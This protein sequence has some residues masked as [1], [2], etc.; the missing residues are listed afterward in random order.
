MSQR[1]RR[2]FA[3]TEVLVAIVVLTLA[4]TGA[5]GLIVRSV[6][7]LQHASHAERRMVRA[8]EVIT[9]TTLRSRA[10]LEASGGSFQSDELTVQVT[11]LSSDLFQISVLD[12]AGAPLLTTSVY[13]PYAH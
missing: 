5:V 4:T 9:R 1:V 8:A 2:G 11:P 3:L 13:R 10:E 7:S 12:G 6:D